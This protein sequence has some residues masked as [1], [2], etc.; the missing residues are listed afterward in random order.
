MY[1]IDEQ[2]RII[3]CNAA[4]AELLG[5][6][7]DQLIGQRCDYH[8]GGK[9][10]TPADI[11]ASLCPLPEVFAGHVLTA[12][13]ALRHRSG[14]LLDRHAEYVPL[15]GDE[16]HCVGVLAILCEPS[17]DHLQREGSSLETATLHRQLARL[18]RAVLAEWPIEE[19]IGNSPAIQRVREQI[20]L[21]SR[22]RTRVLVY[23]PAGSGREHVAR[24][25]HRRATSDQSGPLIPLCCPLLDAELL[26]STIA[27]LVR[28]IATWADQ[29]AHDSDAVG[30]SAP[31]LLTVGGGSNWPTT[32]KPSW[33]VF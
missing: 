22:G 17:S 10:S 9:G 26:Q 16:L 5:L 8:A 13:V 1:A 18:R 24:L 6:D 12:E 3:F 4:C 11:A 25:V 23:G 31:T 20:A 30:T 21:A 28:D 15:G 19:L 27:R 2:R 14:Q 29:R 7:G 33:R 32:R